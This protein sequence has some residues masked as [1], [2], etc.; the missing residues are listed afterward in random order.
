[1][2]LIDLLLYL[3]APGRARPLSPE[4]LAGI[5][6]PVHS[7]VRPLLPLLHHELQRNCA[8]PV[9]PELAAAEFSAS[10]HFERMHKAQAELQAILKQNSITHC[11]IK[12]SDIAD[13]YYPTPFLRPFVDIDLLIHST[14]EDNIRRLLKTQG[15]VLK[16]ERPHYHL[17]YE[18][19]GVPVEVHTDLFSYKYRVLFELDAIQPERVL[20]AGGLSDEE[21]L[22][23][24]CLQFYDGMGRRL[25]PIVDIFQI[26]HRGIDLSRW[27]QLAAS[28]ETSF[29]VL[30]IQ[31]Y[32]LEH[33]GVTLL[34]GPLLAPFSVSAKHQHRL[35]NLARTAIEK[36]ETYPLILAMAARR[37]AKLFR[38]V[39]PPAFVRKSYPPENRLSRLRHWM[40]IGRELSGRGQKAGPARSEKE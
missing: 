12:G 33:F 14:D 22:L 16:R 4:A 1:M 2:E 23:N 25:L 9:P 19:D 5:A 34:T 31:A 28:T 21:Y 26:L 30:F 8:M 29:P 37:A 10:S 40:R 38:L 39:F 15:Y 13:K 17:G 6:G 35:R 24:F 11:I 27:Q 18:K 32:A 7:R 36:R 20:G 3:S